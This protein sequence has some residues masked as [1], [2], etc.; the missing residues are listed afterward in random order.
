MC[1]LESV[2]W[3]ARMR[4]SSCFREVALAIGAVTPGRALIQASEISASWALV[5]AA[6]ESSA[7]R[8]RKPRS[9]KY[10]VMPLPR[11]LWSRSSVERYLPVRNPDARLK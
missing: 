6:T 2:S 7:S 11:G 10:W 4:L 5:S 9:F 1:S 8:M 3:V